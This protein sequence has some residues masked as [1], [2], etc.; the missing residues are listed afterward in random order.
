MNN[1]IKINESIFPKNKKIRVIYNDKNLGIM[2]VEEALKLAKSY[3][4]DLAEVSPTSNPPVCKILNWGKYKY[5]ISKKEKDKKHKPKDH[6][7][8]FKVSIEDHDFDTKCNH[9]RRFLNSGSKVKVCINS[10]GRQIQHPELAECLMNRILEEFKDY[11][12]NIIK[13]NS[14]KTLIFF[15][16]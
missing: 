12:R 8:H 3:D 4:L 1:N 5:E 13:G 16:E 7:I 11:K 9:I 10:K 15:I 6:E 2:V 14:N